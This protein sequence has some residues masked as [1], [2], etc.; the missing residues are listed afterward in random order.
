[1]SLKGLPMSLPKFEYMAPSDIKEACF[2]LKEFNGQVAI[3]AG[4]TDLV[5]HLKHRLESPTH[6]ISLKNLAELNSLHYDRD[7]GFVLGAMC[8]L[9][10][11]S[12]NPSIKS[13][14]GTLARAAEEIASPQIRNRG[15]IGGN[16]CLD[17]RCWYFNRS[18]Q[19][20][21]TLLPCYKT[22]GDRCYVVKRGKHCYALFQADT[23]PNLLVLKAQLRLISTEGERM[24]PIEQFYSGQGEKPNR[25]VSG[26]ILTD[27]KIPRLPSRSG[28]SYLKYRKRRAL[29]FP[30]LGI[31]SLVRLDGEGRNCREARFAFIG[32][33]SGPLLVDA[34][35]A[36]EG[37]DEPILPEEQTTHL[38]EKL[39]PVT[40]MG[41][42][43]SLKRRLARPML[44]RAFYDAWKNAQEQNA[45]HS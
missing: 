31:S 17:S 13:E 22:G 34:S 18:W 36:L 26:E 20:R 5:M 14:L 40:H 3:L 25:L 33:G 29:D 27:V 7:S 45:E 2:Y 28:T 11:I 6:L 39:K 41:I 4:G 43:A 10:D 16:I 1:M 42:S 19:W 24:V 37:L 23:V 35:G 38:L 30:L 9:R 12:V 15:T 8:S 32:H 21:K 44:R